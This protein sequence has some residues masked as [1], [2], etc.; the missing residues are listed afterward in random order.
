MT[1]DYLDSTPNELEGI[2]GEVDREPALISGPGLLLNMNNVTLGSFGLDQAFFKH[3]KNV[4]PG[5]WVKLE[6]SNKQGVDGT[7]DS[8]FTLRSAVAL[9]SGMQALAPKCQPNSE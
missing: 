6:P 9:L 1:N 7:V 8:E 5:C 2:G 4:W 3:V